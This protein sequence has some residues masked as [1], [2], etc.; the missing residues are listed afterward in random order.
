MSG[1]TI[2]VEVPVKRLYQYGKQRCESIGIDAAAPVGQK[3]FEFAIRKREEAASQDNPYLAITAWLEAV[4]VETFWEETQRR[5]GVTSCDA[6]GTRVRCFGGEA[7]TLVGAMP[8]NQLFAAVVVDNEFSNA[9]L[10]CRPFS[11]LRLIERR[12]GDTS[13]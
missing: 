9:G 4:A 11:E 2:S 1:S 8:D 6:P 5:F 10:R 7:A 3:I 12:G 13:E